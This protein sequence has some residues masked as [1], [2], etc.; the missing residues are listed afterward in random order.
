MR[1]SA[2]LRRRW[3]PRPLALAA[4][5][6]AVLALAAAPAR[7]SA[8]ASFRVP[9]RGYVGM[10]VVCWREPGGLWQ[11]GQQGPRA[12]ASDGR[13]TA[14][15]AVS[16]APHHAGSSD[17]ALLPMVMTPSGLFKSI[18]G[19]SH[20]YSFCGTTQAR[21]LY[22]STSPTGGA[23]RRLPRPPGQAEDDWMAIDTA[24]S[25]DGDDSSLCGVDSDGRAW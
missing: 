12:L 5:T 10:P 22:C 14:L 9:M 25:G 18:H 4:I 20:N 16:P 7:G 13:P 11:T 6:A 21:E 2:S 17:P 3:N 8:G 1:P 19:A 23:L 15:C 24:A